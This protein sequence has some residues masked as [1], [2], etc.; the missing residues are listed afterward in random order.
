MSDK[1]TF[2]ISVDI[3]WDGGE[4]TEK[5][6]IDDATY[7]YDDIISAAFDAAEDVG[8]FENFEDI[9]QEDCDFEIHIDDGDLEDLGISN[10]DELYEFCDIFY[11]DNNSYE[12]EVFQAAY[13]CDIPFEDI[14]EMYQGQWDDDETFVMRL[15]EDT[16]MIPSDL[17]NFIRIDW[18]TTAEN[19]MD[20]YVE[21]RGHYFRQ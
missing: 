3:S 15:L 12:I 5:V 14:D 21:H 2:E 13:E 8:V 11:S 10:D 7:D 17:P 18:E 1:Q 4:T 6:I 19:V 9:T 20:D 16:G